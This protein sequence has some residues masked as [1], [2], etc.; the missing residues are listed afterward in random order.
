M[1]L[2]TKNKA[3]ALA[4]E[5]CV[6]CDEPHM[7]TVKVGSGC[8]CDVQSDK[9]PM[10]LVTMFINLLERT[11]ANLKKKNH[12]K[13]R[14]LLMT[15]LLAYLNDEVPSKPAKPEEISGKLLKKRIKHN[16]EIINTLEGLL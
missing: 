11:L 4:R 15:A 9:D 10:T 7:F 13:M 12:S 2:T 16:D 3:M 14:E 6:K 5:L 8:M 1:R